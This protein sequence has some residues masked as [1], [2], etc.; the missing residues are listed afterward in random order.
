MIAVIPAREPDEKLIETVKT[1]FGAGYS[2]IV[3]D[4]SSQADGRLFDALAPFAKVLRTDA[5]GGRGA[6]LKAAFRYIASDAS[7]DRIDGVMTVDAAV[8]YSAEDYERAAEAWRNAPEAVV[9][10]SREPRGRGA[11]LSRIGNGVTRLVFA[12]TTGT[13]LKDVQP[14]LVVFSAGLLDWAQDI[15]G[16]GSEYGISLLISAAK[17]IAAVRVKISMVIKGLT[18]L[19]ERSSIC[20]PP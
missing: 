12:L 16:D 19:A 14:G 20:L 17:K 11:L 8:C 2:V 5:A 9:A 10:G 18:K 15:E 3:A 13:R 1:L 4:C 7:L 6:A